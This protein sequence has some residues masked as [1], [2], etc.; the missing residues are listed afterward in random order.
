MS[1]NGLKTFEIPLQH[2]FMSAKRTYQS[3]NCER[4]RNFMYLA[5]SS[6]VLMN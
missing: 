3:C 1:L 4:S 2:D 6:E 5:S